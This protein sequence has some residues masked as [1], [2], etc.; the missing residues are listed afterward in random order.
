MV[1]RPGRWATSTYSTLLVK[2]IIAPGPPIII[3]LGGE[4]APPCIITCSPGP[5]SSGVARMVPPS[6]TISSA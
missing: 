1:Y 2:R 5:A 3:T 6:L 4:G